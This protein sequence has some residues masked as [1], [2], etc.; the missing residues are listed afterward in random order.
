MHL[1]HVSHVNER[2]ETGKSPKV[3]LRRVKEP[4]VRPIV[5]MLLSKG[6]VSILITIVCPAGTIASTLM[7]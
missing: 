1:A 6:L 5:R 4:V 7:K 2:Q 3:Q